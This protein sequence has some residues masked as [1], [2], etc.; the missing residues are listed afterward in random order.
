M[1]DLIWVGILLDLSQRVMIY[2]MAMAM[3]TI[4]KQDLRFQLAI[5]SS[6]IY[7][8]FFLFFFF[9]F[10]FFFF[11]FF[12]IIQLLLDLCAEYCDTIALESHAYPD[13]MENH[14]EL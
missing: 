4:G 14:Q 7:Y 12:S 10:F 1:Y 2:S 3:A 6:H 11:L 8:Y 9:F 13:A 5:I